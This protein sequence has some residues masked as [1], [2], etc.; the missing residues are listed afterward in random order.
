MIN[1]IATNLRHCSKII[2]VYVA[3]TKGFCNDP[4]NKA[5]IYFLG[6][7]FNSFECAPG[8]ELTNTNSIQCTTG[9]SAN[10]VMWND[11]SLPACKDQGNFGN[12][13]DGKSD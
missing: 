6:E 11:T 13:F 4:L 5:D 3:V 10:E 8:K 7:I 12:V 9:I 2:F 1:I